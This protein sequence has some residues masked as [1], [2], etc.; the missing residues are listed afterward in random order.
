[1]RYSASMTVE[2]VWEREGDGWVGKWKSG[3]DFGSLGQLVAEPTGGLHGGWS[4]RIEG[5]AQSW[6]AIPLE[7]VKATKRACEAVAKALL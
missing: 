5:V 2:I 3:D 7:S 1:M 4:W 6:E